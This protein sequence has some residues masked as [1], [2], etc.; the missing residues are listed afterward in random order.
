VTEVVQRALVRLTEAGPAVDP[1]A[2]RGPEWGKAAPVGLLV[3]VLMG[4]A[5]ALLLR[6]MNKQLK[7]VPESFDESTDGTTPDASD[8]DPV[9]DGSP[10]NGQDRGVQERPTQDRSGSAG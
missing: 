4:L 3:I 2:G 1:A 10:A 9:R 8:V 6:S 7:K 5:V